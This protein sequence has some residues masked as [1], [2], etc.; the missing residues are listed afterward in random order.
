LDGGYWLIG[1]SRDG[2]RRAGARLT[3]GI[4]WGGPQVLNHT[5]AAAGSLGLECRV[6]RR[7]ADLDQRG[8]LAPWR[9]PGR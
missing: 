7:Q 2:F 6:L 1:L 4:P 8:D 9:R 5:L 3:A